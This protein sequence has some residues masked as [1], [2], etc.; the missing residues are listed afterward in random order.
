[1]TSLKVLIEGYAKK[2]SDGWIASSTT[3]LIIENNLKIIVDPGANRDLLLSKLTE[4]GLTPEDINLVFMT[5]YHVDHNLLAGIFTKAKILDDSI[6]YENDKETEYAGT[7]PGTEIKVLKTP[8][9]DQF[10]ASLMVKTSDGIVCVAG[11]VFWWPD[12]EEQ[13][14]DA[15][16]LLSHKDSFVKDEKALLKSRKKILAVADWIIPGHGKMF[17][18]PLK[19][20]N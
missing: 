12:N 20:K 17:K 4:Q 8:G 19:F 13:K 9:H 11:D 14:T 1:M 7:I 10:H 5:H 16:N 18:N 2:I 6:V 3:T 15:E